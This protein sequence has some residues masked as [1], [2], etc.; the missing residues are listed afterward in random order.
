MEAVGA[1]MSWR[2][3]LLALLGLTE[4][5]LP[6]EEGEA[7]AAPIVAIDVRDTVRGC[8]GGSD[9]SHRFVRNGET[10]TSAHGS[11]PA[12]E[13]HALRALILA[14]E[15]SGRDVAALGVTRAA[16][17]EHKA[18]IRKAALPRENP[19]GAEFPAELEGLLDYENIRRIADDN[20]ASQDWSTTT[21]DFSVTF[22]GDE[23]VTVASTSLIPGGLPFTVRVHGREFVT[24]SV[25]VS[26]ALAAL[27]STAAPKYHTILAGQAYWQ[28]GIWSDDGAWD[29]LQNAVEQH[30]ADTYTDRVI[31]INEIRADWNLKTMIGR[32][33]F[34]P[35]GLHM[36][37][38]RK[39]RLL[40]SND[41][42][43]SAW[44]WN[45]IVSGRVTATADDFFAA[46]DRAANRLAAHHWL[47][48]WKD[49]SS[50]RSVEIHVVGADPAG[51]DGN[52]S[53]MGHWQQAGLLGTPTVR[54]LLRADHRLG[55]LWIGDGDPHALVI[56]MQ[57]EAAA[58]HFLDERD[59]YSR[60]M[61]GCLVVSPN[62]QHVFVKC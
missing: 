21:A 55:E 38:S 9:N 10:F 46:R 28:T 11:I 19:L 50:D 25:E 37:M 29:P 23:P 56:W 39:T 30:L 43:D 36:T 6:P 27:V 42:I 61:H 54:V 24:W 26:R 60:S 35:F 17:E 2:I 8:F 62:G 53:A 15:G 45:P 57:P 44:W 22:E 59:I 40:R 51:D 47:A 13:A 20:L 14:S 32:V 18:D 1:V 12:Q 58:K 41:V 16:V 31:G 5:A 34:G 33:N 3:A 4:H 48:Q 49:V 52:S 7:V